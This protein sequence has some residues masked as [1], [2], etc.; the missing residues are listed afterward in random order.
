MMGQKMQMAA[1]SVLTP[2][3]LRT[4]DV[5]G[6]Q[7]DILLTGEQTDGVYSTYRASME[8]GFGSPPHVHHADD[9][10]FVVVEGTFEFLLGDHTVTLGEGATVFLPRH[11]PHC[12]RN[13]G[14]SRGTL[15]G[16]ATPAGH[17]R[18]FEDV[19]RLSF[20]PD[21]AEAAA[22]CERHGISLLPPPQNA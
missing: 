18:F 22:V 8:P 11:V 21:P 12:F 6:V 17:E 2:D 3:A 14:P 4:V 16:T 7:V 15:L 1:P 10:S 13:V 19:S 5:F 9:E 20:P